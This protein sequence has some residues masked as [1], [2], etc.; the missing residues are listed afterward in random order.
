MTAKVAI[1]FEGTRGDSQPYIVAGRALQEAGFDV[2]L[3]GA[4]DSE[5]M[6]KTFG[7]PFLGYLPSSKETWTAP[8]MVEATTKND[9]TEIIKQIDEFK[10]GVYDEGMSNL[11]AKLKSWKPDLLL[12]GMLTLEDNMALAEVLGCAQLL[13][14]LQASL[15]SADCS[16]LGLL[17]KLPYWTGLNKTLWKVL[18]N[19]IQAD[20]E[21]E[22][23]PRLEK[24]FG[25][26][27]A[28]FYPSAAD[29]WAVY[30]GPGINN[31]EPAFPVLVAASSAL[32]TPL[33]CD[34]TPKH[35]MLG[36]LLFASTEQK[37]DMFGETMAKD[38]DDFLKA[39]PAPVYIGYGSV[40]C[41]NGKW[42]TLISLRALK[43]TGQRGILQAGWGGMSADHIEGEP[44]AAEL[45]AYIA[46][47]VLFVPLAPHGVLF[48]QCKVVVHHGGVGHM[49]ASLLSGVPTV[50]APIQVDQFNHSV[51]INERKV[52]VGL[53][54]LADA[55]P[56]TLA[57]AIQKCIDDSDIRN[58]ASAIGKALQAEDACASI[59]REVDKYYKEEIATGKHKAK[60]RQVR[61]STRRSAFSCCGP[62]DESYEMKEAPE[63]D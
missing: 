14:V 35:V 44:D 4:E 59:A 10:K 6:A 2:L 34:F 22:F 61:A 25:F 56:Q 39:G 17:P 18:M 27:R 24:I 13:L 58:N 60:M 57:D 20:K 30:S 62:A 1:I 3:C 26:P 7:V 19:K 46:D 32:N 47:K 33:P 38:M 52:G 50:I 8:A 11:Y 43:I 21:Q 37:G 5:P 55:T 36:P 15:P 31:N 9:I 53:P 63:T 48:P 54:K 41:H 29:K 16:V 40:T 12:G 28:K 45:K 49:N 23:A 51:L 42:M